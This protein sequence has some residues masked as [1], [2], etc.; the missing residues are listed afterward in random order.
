MKQFTK[1]WEGKG[2]LSKE[3]ASFIV[4]PNVRPG[5]KSTFYKTNKPIIHV[6]L[7]TT[8]CNTAIENL[9]IFVDI[10]CAKLNE[11]I[12]TKIN[13]LCH[14]TDTFET[15]NADGIP[16]NAILVPFDIV[17]MFLVLTIIEVLL[18]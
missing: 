16:D 5:K 11:T 8:G 4:N 7:L 17:N 9:A 1:K 2:E 14:L 6:R 3:W 12:P 18:L 10:H 13:D 15:L